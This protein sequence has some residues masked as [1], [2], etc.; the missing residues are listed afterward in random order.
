MLALNSMTMFA[1]DFEV[2]GIAYNITSYSDLT[3]EVTSIGFTE[4]SK[5]SGWDYDYWY[6]NNYTGDIKI[7]KKVFFSGVTYTV[8]GIGTMAFGSEDGY[9]TKI[10][11]VTI[12]E[13]VTYIGEDAF[14]NCNQLTTVILPGSLRII[15]ARA[16]YGCTGIS[17]IMLPN[18]LERIGDYALAGCKI[19][20][21]IV[22]PSLTSIGAVPFSRTLR[23]LVML[24]YYSPEY[25]RD[26]VAFDDG[27]IDN[28]NIEVVVPSK[29]NY[30]N[31]RIWGSR[32]VEMLTPSSRE[33]EYSGQEPAVEWTNNL[34]GYTMNV[35]RITLQKDAGSYST[36]VKADFYKDNVL[37][38][39]VKFPYEYT[40]NK[41]H[42]KAKASNVSRKYGED[43]PLINLTY[44]GFLGDDNESEITIQPTISTTATRTSSVGDYPITISGGSAT[45][46]EFIYEPG[47]LTV[48]KAPLSAKINDERKVYGT[49]N[50]TFIIEY[51][52]LKNGETTPEW[53]TK[54]T[55]QTEATQRSNV[56]LYEVKA[57]NGIPVNYDLG[58]ITPGT[59]NIT[60]APLTIKANDAT[61]QYYAENPQ[62]TYSY[63]GF[64]N[65]D[66]ESELSKKPELSTSAKLTSGVGTYEIKVSNAESRNYS[67]SNVSGKLSVT[68]R[69]LLASVGNY[70][71]YFNEEN[72][73]FEVKYDGFAGNEDESVFN[74]KAVASTQATKTSDVG[75]YPINITGGS[76]DN[77]KF[78]YNN[79]MLT[80]NMAEQII[81]WEQDLSNLKAGDQVELKA[82]ASSG[83]PIT[84]TMDSNG[85]AEIYS[86][87][88]K[89]YLDCMSNGQFIIRAVQEGNKNYYSSPRVSNTVSIIG[90]ATPS[91]PT[92]TIQQADNGSICTQVPK[93]SMYTFTITPNEGWKIHSVTFN[94]VDVTNQ[95]RDG[96][97]FTTPAITTNSMMSVVYEVD[98]I[99]EVRAIIESDV[100]IQGT[101]YGARVKGANKGDVIRIYTMNGSLYH[102]VKAE[103][104]VVDVPL[105]KDSVYIIKV[106]T[107]TMKL[108]H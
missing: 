69:T 99:D 52:G 60:P 41:T 8:T 9:Y 57:E 39:S 23:A 27:V 47:V 84:Y 43:N 70:E 48:T 86:A 50:P 103:Q 73:T 77:Y 85:A 64:V 14:A 34:S 15:Y 82:E 42:L 105:Q 35:S 31:D 40:I 90:N 7:P 89:Q 5:Y 53:T 107:K 44:F 91:D 72:P 76:A 81:R 63:S 4:V 97:T 37:D 61:K 20:K 66:N 62:L 11:S 24:S 6:I 94:D 46:Y 16:F 56:G 58:I 2:D 36:E 55:F 25:E 32:I 12:P 10:T 95:L 108:S 100:T 88:R 80:I 78:S 26:G 3:V 79:G 96:S 13:T 19:V 22:P 104:H 67:I 28:N 98:D 68:P 21:L 38:F 49:Q 1:Y 18:S 71:R 65:G 87:G 45:N 29:E 93:G 59:L 54:P 74:S 101:S 30:N 17:S 102:S 92:L 51:N 75:T 33:F 83:L 106:G